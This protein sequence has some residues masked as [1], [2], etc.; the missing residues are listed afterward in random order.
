M[1]NETTNEITKGPLENRSIEMAQL[2]ELITWGSDSEQQDAIRELQTLADGG[3]VEAQ[4]TLADC[5]QD[6]IGVKQDEAQAKQRYASAAANGDV[7][8]RLL[9]TFAW[10]LRENK[11]EAFAIDAK[12]QESLQRDLQ[13]KRQQQQNKR[14]EASHFVDP[15]PEAEDLKVDTPTSDTSNTVAENTV[16]EEAPT[17]APIE[18]VSAPF[19]PDE[20][21][22]KAAEVE[23]I[24]RQTPQQKTTPI[25]EEKPTI[26]ML[27]ALIEAGENS[28]TLTSKKNKQKAQKKARRAMEQL[29]SL[30]G[31]GDPEI[32]LAL[33]GYYES[34]VGVEQDYEQ[35]AR[36]YELAANQGLADAQTALGNFY[37][38]GVYFQRNF[39][40][41][42]ALYGKAAEQGDP[43]GQ[44]FLG[45]CY[46]LG[47]GVEEDEESAKSLCLLA[48]AQDFDK[49]HEWFTD[50]HRFS[51]NGLIDLDAL[52]KLQKSVEKEF[53]QTAATAE[54]EQQEVPVQVQAIVPEEDA[55][56]AESDGEEDR[57]MDIVEV[58][59]TLIINHENALQEIGNAVAKE[60]AEQKEPAVD[61]VETNTAELQ[62]A[63]HQQERFLQAV[64]ASVDAG[65][66]GG[67]VPSKGKVAAVSGSISAPAFSFCRSD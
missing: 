55:F 37:H 62:E 44:L 34:G 54:S 11:R 9:Q 47:H 41:A 46:L 52:L 4:A 32:Q 24:P 17:Q 38:Q 59:Q 25:E 49:T 36:W 53:F 63:M 3:N 35:A 28:H 67:H 10:D 57:G 5:Y 58:L 56:Y 26:E 22:E 12:T 2:V 33:G 50:M 7:Y 1:S 48:A 15:S 45:I 8:A 23:L 31:Q 20:F 18:V 51:R 21:D 6:G 65:W 14:E 60:P 13:K 29:Q 64:Q 61:E 16:I 27:L 66:F 40:K 30:A 39:V 42:A 43:Q 19:H